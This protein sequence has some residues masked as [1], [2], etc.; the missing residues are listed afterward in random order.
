[1]ISVPTLDQ[2][3]VNGGCPLPKKIMIGST[4]KSLKQD[5]LFGRREHDR[6]ALSVVMKSSHEF[7]LMRH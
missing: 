1:M 3:I 7:V 6:P 4:T 5:D 2:A